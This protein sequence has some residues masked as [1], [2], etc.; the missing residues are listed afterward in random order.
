MAVGAYTR[1]ME[2]IIL[3]AKLTPE[4]KNEFIEFRTKN[5]KKSQGEQT[6]Y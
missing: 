3:D 2:R 6:H 5:Y 1:I 4:R